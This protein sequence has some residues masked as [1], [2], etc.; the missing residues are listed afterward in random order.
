[1]NSTNNVESIILDLVKEYLEKKSFFSI[2]DIVIFINNRVKSNPLINKARIEIIIKDLIKK[3]V[4]IPGTKLMKNNIIEHPVRNEIF[5]YIKKNPSHINEIMKA[6]N[7]GSNQALWHLSCLEKFRFVR[8]K[9]INN[10]RIIF[11]YDSNPEFV[12][13]F[14][15][16]NL[17]IIQEIISFMKKEDKALKI[18]EIATSLKKNHNI[19]KKYLYILKKLKLIKIEKE[20]KRVTFKFDTEK[21]SKV[22]KKVQGV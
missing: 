19:I 10:R 11:K 14:Y 18:T 17:A 21:Y 5:N 9:K 13:L 6:L 20:K 8:S 22:R 3:R 12:E 7:I 15:Y 2:E 16:L 4:I 1:M